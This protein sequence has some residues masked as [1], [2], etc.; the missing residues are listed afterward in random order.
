MGR[1]NPQKWLSFRSAPTLRREQYQRT[2]G[3]DKHFRDFGGALQSIVTSSA[4]NDAGVFDLNL[5]DERYL[6]FEGAGAI[7]RWR[8]ELPNDIPQFDFESISDVVL[9]FRYTAREAGH[10]RSAASECVKEVL[11]F[12][13]ALIQLFCINHDFAGAWHAFA[14]STDNATRRLSITVDQEHFPYWAKRLG[15]NDALVA[16]FA[17]I[18]WAKN[19]LTVAPATAAFAVDAQGGC[20]LNIDQGTA[21][22]PFL[23]RHRNSRVYMAVSY[24]AAAAA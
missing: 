8:I 13:E 2:D 1:H 5:R 20:T 9:H 15:M 6:P 11:R 22:F 10:L 23:E 7:S 21:A 19:T 14:I 16:T 18:D 12:G 17:V 3:E 24:M 4:Q